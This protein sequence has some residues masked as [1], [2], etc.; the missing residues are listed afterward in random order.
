MK[1]ITHC[2]PGHQP[3][4]DI[5]MKSLR[6]E[7]PVEVTFDPERAYGFLSGPF[8][9]VMERKMRLLHRSCAAEQDGGVVIW[10][11]VDI[12]FFRPFSPVIRE[13]LERHPE[14]DVFLQSEHGGM[15]RPYNVGF[16]V[17]RV[18]EKV[19][20][21]LAD[22]AR[23][24]RE[25]SQ[26]P[27]C[28]QDW[29]NEV[30]VGRL[31]TMPLP[32]EFFAMSHG[33]LDRMPR[34][35]ILH[36]ANCTPDPYDSVP[37]K[38]EQMDLARERALQTAATDENPV[39]A[40]PK[41]DLV[42]ARYK[43]DVDWLLDLPEH[44]RIILYNKGPEITDER[45]LNRIII[46][47]TRGNIGRESETYI[48]HIR[49]GRSR[50]ADRVVFSQGD[51]FPHSPDF[52]RLLE[53]HD[54]WGEVQPLSVRWLDT[55]GVPPAR[56][57]H[58]DRGDWL[59]ESQVRREKFSLRSCQPLSFLDHGAVHIAKDYRDFHGVAAGANLVEHFFL[60]VGW[61]EMARLSAAADIGSFGY[62]ALFAVRGRALDRIPPEVLERMEEMAANDINGYFFE[63]LW[64]HFFG[65]G[66][67]KVEKVR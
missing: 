22:G 40:E 58:E 37:A 46:L 45:L 13:L 66:F 27:M 19:R 38:L 57:I 44:F 2:T 60:S 20:A 9:R 33:G 29:F 51:P 50:D 4:F 52:L 43:E 59:G 36:H 53:Q 5:F 14:V 11:D 34:D 54:R 30:A 48:Y 10:A 17:L 67:L 12:R 3:L 64:L 6:D 49:S 32:D 55:H 63:R 16:M 18:S 56:V 47:E 31:E 26:L 39:S 35:P 23:E 1:I 28:E 65:E 61:E 41:I 25:I 21:V 15:S 24:A 8:R 62:G 42:V 7:I